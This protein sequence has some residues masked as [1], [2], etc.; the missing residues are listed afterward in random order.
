M[1]IIIDLH[2]LFEKSCQSKGAIG[3]YHPFEID[4]EI[5]TIRFAKCDE[6]SYQDFITKIFR[7]AEKDDFSTQIFSK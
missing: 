3:Q 1:L 7:N 2:L 4:V 5:L 6:E